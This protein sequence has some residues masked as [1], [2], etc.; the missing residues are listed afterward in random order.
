LAYQPAGCGSEGWPLEGFDEDA[1]P[2]HVRFKCRRM[3]IGGLRPPAAASTVNTR[4][5]EPDRHR[6]AAAGE[7]S[8]AMAGPSAPTIR[9]FHHLRNTCDREAMRC[10]CVDMNLGPAIAARQHEISREQSDA[11]ILVAHALGD[12][13]DRFLAMGARRLTDLEQHHPIGNLRPAIGIAGLTT[14]PHHR[15]SSNRVGASPV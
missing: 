4:S 5:R 14:F 13:G 2:S 15:K 12:D 10:R 1:S 9:L 8:Q 3:P 11:R 7:A 6:A